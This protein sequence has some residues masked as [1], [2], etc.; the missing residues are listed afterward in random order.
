MRSDVFVR[1]DAETIARLL[2][3]DQQWDDTSSYVDGHLIPVMWTAVR[4]AE[5]DGYAPVETVAVAALLHDSI[6][7]VLLERTGSVAAS[8]EWL[9]AHDVPADTVDVIVAVTQ[10]P[11]ESRAAYMTRVAACAHV[12]PVV[13]CV[14]VADNLV[15]SCPAALAKTATVDPERAARL[16]AKYRSDRAILGQA[17]LVLG[18]TP[19]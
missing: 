4:L 8:V 1:E 5:I 7:D 18:G 12:D 13:W 11:G 9:E 3:A 19:S 17:N 2:H 14:K 10:L 16:A 6:E 15:N